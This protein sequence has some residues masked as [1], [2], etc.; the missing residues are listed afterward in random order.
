MSM[1]D[2]LLAQVRS[3]LREARAAEGRPAVAEAELKI[4]ASAL[5]TRRK[6]DITPPAG[7]AN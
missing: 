3:G 1:L 2:T 6:A 5:E 4:R 7:G